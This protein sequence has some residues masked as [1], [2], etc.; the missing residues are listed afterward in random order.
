[1]T[2]YR[3]EDEQIRAAFLQEL[4]YAT[5]EV[6]GWSHLKGADEADQG[7]MDWSAKVIITV[8]DGD[9]L[10]TGWHE[11]D[12][13]FLETTNG[14]D[15]EKRF[16]IFE[17]WGLRIDRKEVGDVSDALDA[18]SADYAKYIPLFADT[19]S[20]G[21]VDLAEAIEDEIE[22]GSGEVVIIDR[23][24]LAP[25]WRGMGGVGRLLIARAVRWVCSEP[26]LVAVHPF[27][28]DLSGEERKDKAVFESALDR[29]RRMWESLAFKQFDDDIWIMN[30]ILAGHGEA[31]HRLE[32]A[33]GLAEED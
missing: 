7:T 13:A 16:T 4:G 5:I 19:Q 18:R 31:V 11:V 26:S 6:S 23:V 20:F 2:G 15:G 28:I 10:Q 30:P 3:V 9:P 12:D 25:A 33:V 17:A 21:V 14:V 24:R 29:V 22:G 8:L 32:V 1:M 27:P